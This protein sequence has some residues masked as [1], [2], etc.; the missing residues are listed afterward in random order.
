MNNLYRYDFNAKEEQPELGL[1]WH[2]YHARNYDAALGRWMNVDPLAEKY[3]SIS[4]YVYVANNPIIYIDPDGKDIIPVHGTW[5]DIKTWGDL[6]GIRKASNN[7]YSDNQLGKSYG[8]SGNNFSGARSDAAIGLIDHVRA[9]MQS[10]DFNGKITLAG[11]SHGGNVSVEALN[12]MVE[13]EEFNDVELNLLTINTPVRDDYQLSEK[14]LERVNHVNVYDEKDPVKR[15]GGNSIW[16]KVLGVYIRGTRTAHR[17][18]AQ[19]GSGELGSA[20]TTF[21]NAQNI[22]VDTPQGL[23]GEFHNS[24]NR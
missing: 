1:N 14:A 15:K 24:H 23:K 19:K 11:H 8:W 9:Q 17:I 10:E 22:S 2:D 7:L 6:S 12:M 13:M 21:N 18:G 5:T 16:N 3:F 4:P 20:S